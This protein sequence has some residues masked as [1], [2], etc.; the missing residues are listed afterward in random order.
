MALYLIKP[1]KT[2]KSVL[3]MG[4]GG[5]CLG[6]GI[7]LDEG[8]KAVGSWYAFAFAVLKGGLHVLSL[9]L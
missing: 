6:T 1:L 2:K 8:F 5:N 7:F 3:K 4:G 9:A